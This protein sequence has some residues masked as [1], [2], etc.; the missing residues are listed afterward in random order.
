[1]GRFT[2]L[3]TATWEK[4]SVLFGYDYI[5]GEVPRPR[6]LQQMI[7]AAEVLGRGLDFIRADFYDTPDRAYLGELTTTPECGYGQFRPKEFDHYL[8]QPLEI[9]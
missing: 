3:Y 1:M 7:A 4:L 5:S 6:H 9:A 2:N 8:R